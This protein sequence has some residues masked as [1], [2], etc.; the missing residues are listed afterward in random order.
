MTNVDFY[1]DPVCP[2]CWVTSRWLL[3]VSEH[4]DMTI[5]WRPF[6]LA[7]KTG[8]INPRDGESSHAHDHRQSHR[9]LRVMT[10][11]YQRYDFALID[12]YTLFGI[13]HHTA[14][15]PYSNKW[16]AT[17]LEEL[18]LPPG[19]IDA[20]DDATLDEWLQSELN[21][22]IDVVG[23]DVGV[24]TIVFTAEDGTRQGYFGPVIREV[25]ALDEALQLWDG[26]VQ[27]A[28]LRSFYE[29]KRS[30]PAGNPLTGS[31]ATC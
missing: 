10:A 4:R 18:Q 31:S 12:S 27:I 6:S 15:F 3:I 23:N 2:W 24:P 16:I 30:R 20:A 19:L 5:N 14:G 17:V 21:S 25:P 9:V 1:F 7:L 29:L 8:S 22:A 28:T 11:A 26:L 13:K